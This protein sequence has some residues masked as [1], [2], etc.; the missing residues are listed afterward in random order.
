VWTNGFVGVFHFGDGATLDIRDVLGANSATNLGAL[1][2]AGKIGGAA[3]FD[4]NSDI[5]VQVAGLDTAAGAVNTI[6]FWLYFEPPFGRGTIA[7]SD[8]ADSAVYD[9][10][11][12]ADGCEGFNT[13]NGDVLGTTASSLANRW[14]YVAAT[15]YNGIPTYAPAQ[16]T[17]S[18][19][20]Y[21]DG[22]AQTLSRS[23]AASPPVTASV[24][25]LLYWG[26]NVRATSNYR[27]VGHL[28]EG[29]LATGA[30][31]AAWIQTELANQGDP[32]TFARLGP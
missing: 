5:V 14:I 21:L 26:S 28:D 10:W 8:A 19:A 11:F 6:T 18:N 3:D 29:R 4:G 15:F 1:A 12:Q 13:G 9:L 30:R 2:T 17:G 31:S 23:C 25:P 16:P 7:F 22:V 24:M 27:M 32:A 20:L